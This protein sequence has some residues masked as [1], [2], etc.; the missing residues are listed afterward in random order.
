[1]NL[2]E[3]FAK[4]FNTSRK[5][6]TYYDT[7]N[8]QWHNI[9]FGDFLGNVSYSIMGKDTLSAGLEKFESDN[10]EWTF[11]FDLSDYLKIEEYNS[12]GDYDYYVPYDKE[13]KILEVSYNDGGVLEHYKSQEETVF[14]DEET[15]SQAKS[16]LLIELGGLESVQGNFAYLSILPAICVAVL[17]TKKLKK[18][19]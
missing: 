15:T 12:T 4:E 13:V 18:D 19:K 1:M 2:N 5:I 3:N 9:T 11:R 7:P 17:I 10:H 16:Y 14:N 8:D 6:Y